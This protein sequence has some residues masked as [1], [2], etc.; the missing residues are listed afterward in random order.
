MD[1]ELFHFL[2]NHN[3]LENG[4]MAK[5]RVKVLKPGKTEENIQD[6]LKMTNHMVK[7]FL[8]TQMDQ[9]I[10]VNSKMVKGMDKAL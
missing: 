10:L 8:S 5:E 2:M 3:I 1:M 7:E 9:N 6:L 4:K